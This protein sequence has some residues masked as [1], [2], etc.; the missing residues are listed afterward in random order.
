MV[1]FVLRFEHDPIGSDSYHSQHIEFAHLSYNKLR[2]RVK[3][4][5]ME[6][7]ANSTNRSLDNLLQVSNINKKFTGTG[8]SKPRSPSDVVARGQEAEGLAEDKEDRHI[9]SRRVRAL[10]AAPRSSRSSR[11]TTTEATCRSL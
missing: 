1:L 2:V 3:I 11:T 6:R 9:R 7:R 10:H 8:G 5:S 4:K